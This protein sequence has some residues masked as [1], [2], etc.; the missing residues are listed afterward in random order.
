[1]PRPIAVDPGEPGARRAEWVGDYL[2]HLGLAHAAAGERD[3]A[4]AA[5]IEAGSIAEFTQ[6]TRLARRAAEL[7]RRFG[8]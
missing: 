6:S 1:M 3:E 5:V 7:K 8:L 2:V 4:G